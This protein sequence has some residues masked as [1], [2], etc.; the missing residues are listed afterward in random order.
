VCVRAGNYAPDKSCYLIFTSL[1]KSWS[2]CVQ[3][4]CRNIFS[5]FFSIFEKL[6]LLEILQINLYTEK[7][8]RSSIQRKWEWILPFQI[9]KG[10]RTSRFFFFFFQFPFDHCLCW[11]LDFALFW[12]CFKSKIYHSSKT[13]WLSFLMNNAFHVLIFWWFFGVFHIYLLI[14]YFNTMLYF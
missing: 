11:T 2:G 6:V 13:T 7:T 4:L 14:C 1:L 10:Q 3:I 5:I 9:G 8:Q 12:F